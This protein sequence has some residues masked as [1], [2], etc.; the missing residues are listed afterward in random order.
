MGEGGWGRG[1]GVADTALMFLVLLRQ[2]VICWNDL[3]I[4]TKITNCSF[5]GNISQVSFACVCVS[6]VWMH[7]EGKSVHPTVAKTSCFNATFDISGR[8]HLFYSTASAAR[9]EGKAKSWGGPG[10][11]P[12]FKKN[13]HTYTHSTHA[14]YKRTLVMIILQFHDWESWCCWILC[15]RSIHR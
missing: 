15:H 2:L 12:F 7:P 11:G 9:N 8:T 6:C 1:M 13:A 10:R 14:F 3:K 5:L 4:L